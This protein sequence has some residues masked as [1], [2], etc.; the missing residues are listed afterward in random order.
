MRVIE[1]DKLKQRD[2]NTHIHT[3]VGTYSF[4][5]FLNILQAKT[6]DSPVLAFLVALLMKATGSFSWAAYRKA[7]RINSPS[8]A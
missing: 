3:Q 7:I 2:S 4:S 1:I 6:S 5:T 8:P